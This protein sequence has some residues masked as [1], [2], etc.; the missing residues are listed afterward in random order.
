LH[1]SLLHFLWCEN[2]TRLTGK[3]WAYLKVLQTEYKNLQPAQFSDLLVLGGRQL[4]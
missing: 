1:K 4:L 2:T 3:P